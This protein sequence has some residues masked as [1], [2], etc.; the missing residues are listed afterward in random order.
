[1][2]IRPLFTQVIVVQERVWGRKERDLLF[3]GIEHYGVGQWKDIS[4]NLL[5]DWG[6]QA[7]RLWTMRMLGSQ[8]LARYIGWKASQEEVE[9]ERE[10][11]RD[12]GKRLGCWKGGMLVEDDEGTVAM[13]LEKAAAKGPP[14]DNEHNQKMDIDAPQGTCTS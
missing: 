12:L 2:L 4:S 8:S 13:E 3:E 11:N 14:R 9:E 1:M 6:E 5:P 10:K 7:I